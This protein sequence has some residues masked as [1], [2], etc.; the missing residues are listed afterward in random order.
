MPG[1]HKSIS[2]VSAW[3]METAAVPGR[4]KTWKEISSLDRCGREH[5]G[6]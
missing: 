4:K 5:S 3:L 6:A 1:G 2:E